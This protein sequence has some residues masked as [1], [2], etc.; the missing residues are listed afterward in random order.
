[1][2]FTF[3]K[4]EDTGLI[5]VTPKFFY[6]ERG[7]FLEAFKKR[8][9]A[10]NGINCEFAQDNVSKSKK[11]VLR[12]LHYQK[13]PYSQ[14]KL[15]ACLDGEIIDIVV[16]IRP[17]S[18]YYKQYF[19]FSLTSNDRKMLYVPGGFAHGFYTISDYAVVMYKASAIYNPQADSGIIWNDPELA[20]EWPEGEKIISEKDLN[21]PKLS[22]L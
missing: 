13:A 19:K 10:E 4:I 5:V 9:F 15:V 1:M 22:E 12:G 8:D 7:Y 17:E 18:K 16:D 14:D 11:G 6:D 20:I 3:E 2:P 21:L